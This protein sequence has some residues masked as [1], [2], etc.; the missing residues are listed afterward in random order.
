[1]FTVAFA[2]FA[3]GEALSK[4]NVE[5]ISMGFE[6]AKA[7]AASEVTKV[8]NNR[9]HRIFFNISLFPPLVYSGI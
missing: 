6:I 7:C 5:R 2:G 8:K 9:L 4:L 3:K 1:M